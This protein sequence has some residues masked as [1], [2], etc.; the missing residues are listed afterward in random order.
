MRNLDA[1]YVAWLESL[2]SIDNMGRTPDYFATPNDI[3]AKLIVGLLIVAA[4][5]LYFA[6]T[7]VR[8]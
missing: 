8:P 1:D 7:C 3:V 6:F 4:S 2:P 5:L